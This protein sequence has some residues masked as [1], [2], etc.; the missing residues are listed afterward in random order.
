MAGWASI[1]LFRLVP[2]RSLALS[3]CNACWRVRG[4]KVAKCL[5]RWAAAVWC[6][7]A[8]A[9]GGAEL[10]DVADARPAWFFDARR[11]GASRADVDGISQRDR[12]LRRG[13][14]RF[15]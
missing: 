1:P 10:E 11:M 7:S 14:Q 3:K 12:D 5:T 15:A 8:G 9:V 6:I 13:R 2:L 4:S